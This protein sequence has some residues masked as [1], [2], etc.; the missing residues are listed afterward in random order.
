MKN[1][2]AAVAEIE[3]AT[4]TGPV[5]DIVTETGIEKE[6]GIDV[7]TGM[8]VEVNVAKVATAIATAITVKGTKTTGVVSAGM[9]W[10]IPTSG[11]GTSAPRRR[12]P[13]LT[14]KKHPLLVLL[15]VPL[16]AG[17]VPLSLRTARNSG[18]LGIQ[19]TKWTTSRDTAETET[20][21]ETLV[22]GMLQGPLPMMTQLALI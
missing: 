20:E 16:T 21:T 5:R 13:M 8:G 12:K 19:G 1:D 10:M 3:V 18:F 15:V 2:D 14:S 6:T 7:A 11:T 22:A 9:R 4:E 17:T